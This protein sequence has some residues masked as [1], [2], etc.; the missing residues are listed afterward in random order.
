MVMS[1]NQWRRYLVPL[2]QEP[3]LDHVATIR[4]GTKSLAYW[5]YKFVTD[6]E[7]DDMLR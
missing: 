2:T 1:A 3:G 5:P 4:I 6:P 7:A